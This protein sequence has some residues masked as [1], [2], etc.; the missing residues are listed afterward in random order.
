MSVEPSPKGNTSAT[1]R[2]AAVVPEVHT[3]SQSGA[4][5]AGGRP[6]RV[7]RAPGAGRQ[8]EG[9]RLRSPSR[10]PARSHLLA[11]SRLAVR[12]AVAHPAA[13]VRRARQL[14]GRSRRRGRRGRG[15]YACAVYAPYLSTAAAVAHEQ[16]AS[17]RRR[18]RM[19]R[20]TRV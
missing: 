10:L 4:G 14:S 6:A 11:R 3:H 7:R 19:R 15:R 5:R 13:T 18:A 8:A 1:S 2:R 16:A 17:R 12:A 20:A 9:Q